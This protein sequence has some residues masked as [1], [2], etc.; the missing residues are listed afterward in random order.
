MSN[1]PFELEEPTAAEAGQN[2]GTDRGRN[3]R[4]QQVLCRQG[5]PDAIR[6][7]CVGSEK[8]PAPPRPQEGEAIMS[9]HHTDFLRVLDVA[10]PAGYFV[11]DNHGTDDSFM[12]ERRHKVFFGPAT[13]AECIAWLAGCEP[14]RKKQR[15]R[16][17]PFERDI[18]LPSTVLR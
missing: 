11:N 18:A 4:V 14:E 15:R 12:L 1:K 7:R 8:V 5:A 9:A 10:G 13:S 17:D 2:G 6:P 3:A 16:E